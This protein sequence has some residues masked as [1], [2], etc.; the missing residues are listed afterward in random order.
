MSN[1]AFPSQASIRLFIY[2]AIGIVISYIMP[3]PFSFLTI[4]GT[5]ILIT[6]YFR[7]QVL[8]IIDLGISIVNT[9]SKRRLKYYYCMTCGTQHREIVCPRCGSRIK[10]I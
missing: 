1:K 7:D 10:K 4:L 9:F 6:V 8:S 5:V 2:F 3:F